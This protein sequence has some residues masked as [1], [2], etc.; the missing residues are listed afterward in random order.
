MRVITPVVSTTDIDSKYL[1]TGVAAEP[2][3]ADAAADLTPT[4]PP[5]WKPSEIADF[6]EEPATINSD[7]FER[8]V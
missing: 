1:L 4:I 6:T 7:T 2:F 5:V 8:T 3:V